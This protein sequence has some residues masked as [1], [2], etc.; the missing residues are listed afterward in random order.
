[1]PILEAVLND[2]EPRTI[3]GRKLRIK[4]MSLAGLEDTGEESRRRD[5]FGDSHV[6]CCE[7]QAVG[8]QRDHVIAPRVGLRGEMV[9][10]PPQCQTL[11]C[12]WS[13]ST[14]RIREIRIVCQRC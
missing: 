6:P 10:K 5:Y 14:R 2:L 7:R 11:R 3:S 8:F 9:L 13:G 12:L 1:M 4:T